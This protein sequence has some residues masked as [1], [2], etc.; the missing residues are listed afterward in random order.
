MSQSVNVAGLAHRGG[1]EALST[2][3]LVSVAICGLLAW[4]PYPLERAPLGL[5]WRHGWEGLS[6]LPQR[7]ALPPVTL[8]I[9]FFFKSSN[10]IQP[11]LSRQR[12]QWGH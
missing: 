1:A 9:F 8:S 6:H 2:L 11:V 7:K 4:L 12:K 3:S 10:H 5:A